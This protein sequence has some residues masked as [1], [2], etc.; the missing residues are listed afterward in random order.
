MTRTCVDSL[1]IVE[2]NVDEE[3]VAINEVE[4]KDRPT[5]GSVHEWHHVDIESVHHS[6]DPNQHQHK[7]KL[8]C[9]CVC[10][11]VYKNVERGET[12]YILNT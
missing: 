10:L 4:S 8:V 6:R 7:A 11:C 9:M 1:E 5:V 12:R 2:T 3:V